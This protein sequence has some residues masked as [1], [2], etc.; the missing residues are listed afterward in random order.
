VANTV[1]PARAEFGWIYLQSLIESAER[2]VDEHRARKQRLRAWWAA[3]RVEE[4]RAYEAWRNLP[5]GAEMASPPRTA[6]A[7]ASAAVVC[8]VA[9]AF[10]LALRSAD[11]SVPVAVDLALLALGSIWFILGVACA[12]ART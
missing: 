4:L 9:A 2:R 7:V 12:G 8:A 10:V 3:R 5:A 11:G 6:F 1:R